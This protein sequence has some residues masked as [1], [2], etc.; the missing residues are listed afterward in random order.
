MTRAHFAREDV[1]GATLVAYGGGAL[2]VNEWVRRDQ[3]SKLC[4]VIR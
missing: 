2:V 4:R 1:L 3:F